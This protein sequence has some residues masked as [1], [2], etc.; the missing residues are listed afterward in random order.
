MKNRIIIFYHS[1]TAHLL[2]ARCFFTLG[3]CS[4]CT[5]DDETGMPALCDKHHEKLFLMEGRA[6]EHFEKSIEHLV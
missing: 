4:N 2:M 1:M 5:F 3:L 6:Y